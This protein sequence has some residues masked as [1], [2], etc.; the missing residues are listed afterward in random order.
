MILAQANRFNVLACGRRWGKTVLGVDLACNVAV[1]S[2]PVG[3]FAPNYKYLSEAWK[4]ILKIVT[5]IVKS[6]NWT[7]KQIRLITEGIID[8][9]TLD[10]PD[11]GRGR[12]YK[13]AVIDE[14]AKPSRG[15]KSH[16]AKA[17]EYA[18]SP[19]LID[20]KGNAWFLSTPRGRDAFHRFYQLG[21]DPHETEWRSWTQPTYNNPYMP[22][23]EIFQAKHRMPERAFRQ[24]IL[25]QFLESGSGVFLNVTKSVSDRTRNEPATPGRQYVLGCD[26]ARKEDFTVISV[27]DNTGKQVYFLRISQMS[28]ERQIEAIVAVA[29]MYD[30]VAVIDSTGV[31]DPIFE[32]ISRV[33]G[34]P[35]PLAYQISH[36]SKTRLIDG[37]GIALE[38]GQINLMNVDVQ[39]NELIGYEY[40]SE[41][42]MSVR[43]SA[44]EGEHDDCVIA[45]ALAVWGIGKPQS[46]SFGVATRW[47]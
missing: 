21:Q 40:I 9:W 22:E 33:S 12:K 3:W 27:L 29:K 38:H 35:R 10:D 37:L 42:G 39:T 18:I 4:D 46:V 6:S 24:E 14:A 23:S 15:G 32:R 26:L 11:A 7:D 44:P 1:T 2:D 19:T 17:W 28:W 16:L 36:A 30:A 25:A 34:I 31:G 41:P 45:L 20:L 47:Q 43:M 13:L 8:F 5:P